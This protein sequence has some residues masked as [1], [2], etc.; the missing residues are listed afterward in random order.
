MMSLK[1]FADY[2]IPKSVI[3]SLIDDGYEVL[4]LK[5]FLPADSPDVLV[6]EKAQEMD[7]ILLSLNGDFTDII[8]YPPS[9]YKGIIA[10]QVKNHPEIIPELIERLKKYLLA[11]NHMKHYKGKLIIVES[12]RIR[13]RE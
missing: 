11:H 10:L 5:N 9:N 7:A 4:K 3:K 1:L 12:H 13:I 2:C 6:I 8:T